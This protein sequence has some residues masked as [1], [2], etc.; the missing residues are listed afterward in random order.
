MAPSSTLVKSSK[1]ILIDAWQAYC[2]AA[3]GY[4]VMLLCMFP[5]LACV[6]FRA[7]THLN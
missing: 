4:A 1:D 7:G 6:Q 3:Y 5:G 2:T